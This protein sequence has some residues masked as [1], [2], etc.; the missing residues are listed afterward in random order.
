M[1]AA[2]FDFSYYPHLETSR[3]VLRRPIDADAP[4]LSEVYREPEMTRYVTF[5]AQQDIGD[6][7]RFLAWIKDGFDRKDSVRWVIED[8]NSARL[9]GTAG[10][11]FWK[12]DIRCA[13]AG[14]HIGLPYWRNGYA[15]ECLRAM[16]QFGFLRMN[17]NR[18][19]AVV[20][21]GNAASGRV[22]EKV[23]FRHEGILRQ[24]LSIQGKLRDQYWY[25]L[26]SA[27]Y[28]ADSD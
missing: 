5:A 28:L 10:L 24:R 6:A 7:L 9:I 18:I 25:S 14:Y 12:R 21:E 23:G 11:H 22:L 1:D 16:V 17:L 13:E 26:L 8:K 15:T 4:A 20:A 3:L 19:E 27:E 2:T